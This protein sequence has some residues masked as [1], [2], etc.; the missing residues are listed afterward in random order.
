MKVDIL[1]PIRFG[2]PQ[3]WGDDLV[4]KLKTKGIEAKNIHNFWGIIKRFF[5]TDADIVHT[6]LPL[7]FTFHNKPVI[8]TIHGDYTRE[9]NIGSYLYGLAIKKAKKITVP[10]EFLKKELKLKNAIVIPNGIFPED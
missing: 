2:G 7:F 8:L 3:K 4:K 9:K 6:T 5:W 10:S 1:T